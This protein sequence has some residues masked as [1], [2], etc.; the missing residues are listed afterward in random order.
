LPPLKGVELRSSVSL[1]LDQ[2]RVFEVA[3][4]RLF[5]PL[6]GLNALYRWSGGAGQTSCSFLIGREGKGEKMAPFRLDLGPRV[7]R[8]LGM[9]EHHVQVRR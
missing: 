9:R 7:F 1:P 8:G 4:R 5:V 6:I 2:L 3:E